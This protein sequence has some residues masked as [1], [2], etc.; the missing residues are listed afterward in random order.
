MTA[1]FWIVPTRLPEILL[2]LT[3]TRM[4]QDNL[5]PRT[6]SLSEAILVIPR[7]RSR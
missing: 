2:M 5:P 3:A 7:L 6:L 1:S 4:L